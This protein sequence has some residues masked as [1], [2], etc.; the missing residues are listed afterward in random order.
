MLKIRTHLVMI[1]ATSLLPVVIFSA[2]ALQLLRDGEREAALHGLHE[3]ARASALIV[4][5]ELGAS[6][7]MLE[8]L[9]TSPS[10]E[11]GDLRGFY[12]LAKPMSRS[13]PIWLILLDENGQQL[14]NT[15]LPFGATDRKSVV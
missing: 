3:T 12:D 14:V 1:A 2:V 13:R 6:L 10:L 4:D 5:R 15:R 11:T 7:A 9:V 8:L